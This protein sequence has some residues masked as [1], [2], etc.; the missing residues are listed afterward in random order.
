MD[1]QSAE[2]ALV[3]HDYSTSGTKGDAP[4]SPL[5]SVQ[6]F[7]TNIV[8]MMYGP[9][10]V[11]NFGYLSS[12][13]HSSKVP[14]SVSSGDYMSAQKVTVCILRLWYIVRIVLAPWIIAGTPLLVSAVLVNGV[15]GAILTFLFV[16]SHNFEGVDRN[17]VPSNPE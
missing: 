17:P 10:I 16:V 11:Y 5:L 2:P 3:F 8:L 9:S 7:A 13:R 14:L 15:C 12:L 6:H 4:W 1:A